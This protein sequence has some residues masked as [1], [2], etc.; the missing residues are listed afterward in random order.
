MDELDLVKVARRVHA[1]S[2]SDAA[3]RDGPASL[4]AISTSSEAALE[5][6]LLGRGL[7]LEVLERASVPSGAVAIALCAA[8]WIV[9]DVGP[10]DLRPS[11]HP[12]RRRV[13]MTSVIGGHGEPELVTLIRVAGAPE[14]VLIGGD[15]EIPDALWRSWSQMK[16]SIYTNGTK[17]L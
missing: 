11:R 13:A 8:G 2:G 1:T 12:L 9:R 3:D 7:A 15:G 17:Y 4:F 10:G 14:E 5:L 16:H 6:S